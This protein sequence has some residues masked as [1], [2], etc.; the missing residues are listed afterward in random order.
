MNELPDTEHS[1][2]QQMDDGSLAI[3]ILLPACRLEHFVV[4]KTA[5]P[6]LWRIAVIDTECTGTNPLTDQIIDLAY[7]VVV[8]DAEGDIVDIEAFREGL[9]DPMVP[10]PARVTKLTG[11]TDD[12]VA[13]KAIDLDLVEQDFAQV[14]VFVA[15][16]AA[17]DLAFIRQLIPIANEACWACSLHDFDWLEHAGLDGRSLGHLLM[18]IGFYNDAHRAMAD[19][20]SLVHL[21]AYPLPDGRPVLATLLESAAKQTYRIEATRA[22]FDARG[23]LKARGYRWNASAKVWWTEVTEDQLDDEV[24]WIGREVTPYG[25]PPRIEPITWRERHR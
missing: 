18:Q 23:L 19:V 3:R 9:C 17:F 20:V 7:A 16:N 15:H 11:I 2:M 14:D 13:G 22:P 25:P 21:L 6:P 12:D 10:I 24:L 5:V 1:N 8:V 4:N